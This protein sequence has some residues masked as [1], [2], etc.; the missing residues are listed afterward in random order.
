MRVNAQADARQF[1]VL[2][3]I[4]SPGSPGGCGYPPQASALIS[5]SLDKPRQRSALAILKQ[6][7]PVTFVNGFARSRSGLFYM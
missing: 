7:P 6:S 2:D 4:N 3:R 1:N 5:G